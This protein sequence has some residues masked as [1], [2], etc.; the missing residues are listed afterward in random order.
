MIPLHQERLKH[1]RR[2]HYISKVR[3]ILFKEHSCITFKTCFS[4]MF[5]LNSGAIYIPIMWNLRKQDWGKCGMGTTV[6]VGQRITFQKRNR[7]LDLAPCI[8]SKVAFFPFFVGKIL[9]SVLC[10]P[11]PHHNLPNTTTELHVFLMQAALTKPEFK[12]GRATTLI[13]NVSNLSSH[14]W[15]GVHSHSAND[16][17]LCLTSVYHN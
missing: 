2:C 11:P 13:L 8:R 9:I 5:H 4:G 1:P 7:P 15:S 3:L 10:S 17:W 14:C 6:R 12:S 16:N